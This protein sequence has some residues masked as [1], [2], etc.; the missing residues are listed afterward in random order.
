MRVFVTGAAGFV[1]SAVVPDRM[2]TPTRWLQPAPRYIE[3]HSR[4]WTA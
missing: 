4:I 1:G 2:P 3:A